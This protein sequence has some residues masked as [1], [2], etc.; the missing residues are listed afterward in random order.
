MALEGA[1]DRHLV[2]SISR[3]ITQER[4]FFLLSRWKSQRKFILDRNLNLL[5]DLVGSPR[6]FDA[7]K[8]Q[9]T[10]VSQLDVHSYFFP[11]LW[12]LVAELFHE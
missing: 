10:I 11:P 12:N 3:H 2:R 5:K 9:L 8:G 7:F 4:L 1:L 6:R